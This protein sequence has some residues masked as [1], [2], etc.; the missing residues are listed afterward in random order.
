MYFK[1]NSKII[2]LLFI[3]GATAIYRGNVATC[4]A[5]KYNVYLENKVVGRRRFSGRHIIKTG[6]QVCSPGRFQDS[7]DHGF[8]SCHAC[9]SGKW[10]NKEG[11]VTCYDN[12]CPAG[13]YG[14]IAA[15]NSNESKCFSCEPGK[16]TSIA[17]YGPECVNCQAGRNQPSSEMT[18]CI[19]DLCY[20][21]TYS[22]EGATNQNDSV[23][24]SCSI[25]KFSDSSGQSE[26]KMCGKKMY[27]DDVGQTDCKQRTVCGMAQTFDINV[28]HCIDINPMMPSL[29]ISGI[30]ITVCLWLLSCFVG[31]FIVPANA[32]AMTILTIKFG[33]KNQKGYRSDTTAY[34]YMFYQIIAILWVGCMTIKRIKKKKNNESHNGCDCCC[35]P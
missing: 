13:K 33:I 23:C 10:Q 5:G 30:I 9:P 24:K 3:S 18:D 12:S 32:I 31:Y 7:V 19:G 22:M 17:G 1:F 28:Y 16:Y 35:L 6:C 15:T 4:P 26:C 29:V 27:Q 20:P 21:G 34:L 2:S 14:K 11:G 25:G 8:F